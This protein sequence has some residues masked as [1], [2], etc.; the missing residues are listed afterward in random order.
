MMIRKKIWR[1]TWKSQLLLKKG[2]AYQN[3]IDY[4]L[5][6]T[7]WYV[8]QMDYTYRFKLFPKII[9]QYSYK[10]KFF[11]TL[12]KKKRLSNLF[13]LLAIYW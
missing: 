5:S 9:D 11:I 2:A 8:K 7:Y 3:D 13:S 4:L 1:I 12:E 6:K 10:Y